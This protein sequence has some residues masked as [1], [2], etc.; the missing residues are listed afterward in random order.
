[1]QVWEPESRGQVLQVAPFAPHRPIG[2]GQDQ[3]NNPEERQAMA[4]EMVSVKG[5]L[6]A[7]RGHM[8][9]AIKHSLTPAVQRFLQTMHPLDAVMSTS[10]FF[11]AIKSV[12]ELL[13][14]HLS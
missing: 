6:G 2:H 13:K 14:V 7:V 8:H 10:A 1:M 3:M 5:R 12:A 11:P 4:D 9:Y